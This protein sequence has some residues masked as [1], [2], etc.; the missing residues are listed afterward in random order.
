MSPG[1]VASSAAPGLRPRNCRALTCQWVAAAREVPFHQ[2]PRAATLEVDECLLV[3]AILK[4]VTR[5][6]FRVC[7]GGRLS[8]WV[9]V[10]RGEVPPRQPSAPWGWSLQPLPSPARPAP[11]RLSSSR[12]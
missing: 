10:P 11:P 5:V 6:K 12:S 8:A 7:C 3:S 9:S 1:L 4:T 2:A